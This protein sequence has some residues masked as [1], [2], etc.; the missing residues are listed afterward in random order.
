MENKEI[1][2]LEAIDIGLQSKALFQEKMNKKKRPSRRTASF[3][4]VGMTPDRNHAFRPLFH[5][6]IK[7]F[8]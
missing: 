8:L 6:G 3:G 2:K 1:C 7:L 4:P 5:I